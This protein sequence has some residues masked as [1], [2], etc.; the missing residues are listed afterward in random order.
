MKSSTQ[1]LLDKFSIGTSAVCAI[2]CAAMPI[3]LA[4]FPTLSFLPAEE[5]TFHLALV[6]LIV[7]MSL[8]AGFLGC[9]QHKDRI[10]LSSI[11]IGLLLLV[12][13]A[14]FGHDVVGETGEKVATVIA[15]F[16]LAFAHWRNFSLC[17]KRECEDHTCK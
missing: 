1:L 2:H 6:F 16:I 3:V 17:K 10:V 13:T 7:P 11:V 4:L 12:L 14:V 9:R 5:H 8:V 15:T